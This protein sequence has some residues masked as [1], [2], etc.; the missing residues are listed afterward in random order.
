[1]NRRLHT[2]I[3]ACAASTAMLVLGLLVAWPAFPADEA[4]GAGAAPDVTAAAGETRTPSKAAVDVTAAP[5]P[6]SRS[7]RA[8]NAIALPYFSFARGTGGRS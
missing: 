4:T 7:K 8:L 2:P 1:M 6:R 3:F 5:A